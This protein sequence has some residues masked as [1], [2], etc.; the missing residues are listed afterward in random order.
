MSCPKAM[1]CPRS[2]SQAVMKL[3]LYIRKLFLGDC[4]MLESVSKVQYLLLN[5]FYLC[6][7]HSQIR[8]L[9]REEIFVV[10]FISRGFRE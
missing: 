9:H 2:Y 7:L 4:G 10:L 8:T 5:L 1:I 6:L 3:G